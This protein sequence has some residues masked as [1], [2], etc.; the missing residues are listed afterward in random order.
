MLKILAGS[1]QP[2]GTSMFKNLCQTSVITCS[3]P[4]L[5]LQQKYN[6]FKERLWKW[7]TWLE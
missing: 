1:V 6:A 7:I 2:P 5:E 3:M 4:M